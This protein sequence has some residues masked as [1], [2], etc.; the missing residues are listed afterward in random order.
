METKQP[1]LSEQPTLV[2]QPIDTQPTLEHV[3][4]PTMIQQ[5]EI[6]QNIQ[7][8]IYSE[9]Q[10]QMAV[11][12][13]Q[14]APIMYQQDTNSFNNQL[15]IQQGSTITYQNSGKDENTCLMFNLIGM[16]TGLTGLHHFYLGN[17]LKGCIQLFFGPVI[18]WIIFAFLGIWV[19]SFIYFFLSII[20]LFI[21]S[22][23]GWV[24]FLYPFCLNAISYVWCIIDLVK[25]KE[26]VQKSNL[27]NKN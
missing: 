7:P 5:N 13:Q 19:V 3:I 16:F 4:Q 27:N 12:I 6:P 21:F 23:F 9:Q 10:P 17:Y 15:Y 11:P 20:T 25:N 2:Q 8:Q 22:L 24:I 26:L 14:Q 18:Q 1:L